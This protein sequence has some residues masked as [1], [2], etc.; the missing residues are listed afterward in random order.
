MMRKNTCIMLKIITASTAALNLIMLAIVPEGKISVVDPI[1]LV[2][3]QECREA[4][5]IDLLQKLLL[6]K[7]MTFFLLL[8]LL[9]PL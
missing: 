7:H 9:T 2:P 3:T 4:F 1:F 5:I 8:L 6:S